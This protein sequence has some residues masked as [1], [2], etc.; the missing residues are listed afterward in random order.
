MKLKIIEPKLALNKAFLKEKV[1]RNDIDVFK[2]NL[3][4]LL[5][6]THDEDKEEHDKVNLIKYLNDTY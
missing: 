2:K 5:S 6:N 3:N 1:L 4:I